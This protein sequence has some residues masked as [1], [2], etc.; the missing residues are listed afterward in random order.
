MACPHTL[1]SLAVYSVV[2][3]LFLSPS[4]EGV[5]SIFHFYVCFQ[6]FGIRIFASRVGVDSSSY[7]VSDV[8]NFIRV[9]LG[10]TSRS[11]RF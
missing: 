5:R 3:I 2:G 1:N 10:A 9:M 6:S 7:L 8:G 4:R 11:Q